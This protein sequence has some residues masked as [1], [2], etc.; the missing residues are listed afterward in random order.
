MIDLNRVRTFLAVAQAGNMRKAASRLFI[1]QPAVSHQVRLLEEELGFSLFSRVGR[2][3]VLTPEGRSLAQKAEMLIQGVETEIVSSQKRK[4]SLSGLVRV[5]ALSDYANLMLF[6]RVRRFL[7]K[8]SGVEVHWDFGSSWDSESAVREM[9]ADIGFVARL[10]STEGLEVIPFQ[11]V[12]HQ[13]YVSVKTKNKP[14]PDQVPLIDCKIDFPLIGAWAGANPQVDLG[15]D[16]RR[17]SLLIS[18]LYGVRDA[19][20]QGMGA[21]VLPVFAATRQVVPMVRTSKPFA[22]DLLL[23]R[24]KQTVAPLIEAFTHSVRTASATAIA[25]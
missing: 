17:P 23:I 5:A 14:E 15:L 6:P 3:L 19:V 9:K 18:T 12:P 8:N 20:E 16:R 11:E 21:G 7:Q 2:G 24:R 1:T 25:R 13:L 22:I 10:R 4:K